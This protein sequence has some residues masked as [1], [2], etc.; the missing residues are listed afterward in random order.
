MGQS[1]A[2]EGP[3]GGH[4]DVPV[5]QAPAH[6]LNRGLGARAQDLDGL[7]RKRDP[8]GSLCVMGN[9]LE[10]LKPE[11]RMEEGQIGGDAAH[12]TALEGLA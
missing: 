7:A 5:A 12:F 1:P 10:A 3:G 6:I 4:A 8:I 2:I 9:T 11:G